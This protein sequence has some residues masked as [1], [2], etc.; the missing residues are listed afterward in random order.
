MT[1]PL[2]VAPN[3]ASLAEEV[4]EYLNA[5]AQGLS[6][7]F[8]E[9]SFEPL[10]VLGKMGVCARLYERVIKDYLN[11]FSLMPIELQVLVTLRA[12]VASA[13]AALAQATQQT[14]AGMTS[15]LDRLEKRRLIERA[16]H[17]SDRRRTTISL[18]AAGEQ[19]T[20][21]LIQ[22]QNQALQKRMQHLS[23]NQLAQLSKSLD[24][25]IALMA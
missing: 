19:L 25:L 22:A 3:P 21:Q 24:T 16:P 14:R 10:K 4:S 15:T 12:Q 5:L 18:T 9:D 1:E 8:P 23:E 13:P 2:P 6:G 11:S 17:P 7:D 20:N